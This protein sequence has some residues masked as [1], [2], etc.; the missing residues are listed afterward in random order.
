MYNLKCTIRT[1]HFLRACTTLMSLL[2]YFL[3]L[4]TGE[5]ITPDNKTITQVLPLTVTR[6][7]LGGE[8]TC[9]VSSAALDAD[10]VKT[11]KLDVRGKSY[12]IVSLLIF[13]KYFSCN[14]RRKKLQ[15]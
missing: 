4:V 13:F 9:V 12:N 2:I 7:E 10:I 1:V 8:L 14:L 3:S 15:P 11:I 5:T 6:E